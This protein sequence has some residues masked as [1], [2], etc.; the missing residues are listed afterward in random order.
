MPRGS[1][2][3]VSGVIDGKLYVLHGI[4]NVDEECP[5][6]IPSTRPTRC[7]YRYDPA[8]DTWTKLAWCPNFHMLG[9]AGVIGESSTWLAARPTSS[10]STIR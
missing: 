2:R 4:E 10:I 3:G 8:T 5:D 1:S 7:F 9:M 6:C